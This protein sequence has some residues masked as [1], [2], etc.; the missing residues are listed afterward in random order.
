MFS[1]YYKVARSITQITIVMSKSEEAT[2]S[3]ASML[4]TPLPCVKG[5]LCKIPLKDTRYEQV[6][7]HT[8]M[9]LECMTMFASYREILL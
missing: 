1:T 3:S 8:Y 5:M 7:L 6:Q 2:A 4:V 9:Y